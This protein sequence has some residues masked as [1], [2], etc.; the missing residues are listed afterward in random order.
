MLTKCPIPPTGPVRI[1]NKA[2][3][4][5]SQ[6]TLFLREIASKHEINIV[7][8]QKLLFGLPQPLFD[9][10]VG[11]FC[12]AADRVLDRQEATYAT[13]YSLFVQ[14]VS[15]IRERIDR[16]FQTDLSVVSKFTLDDMVVEL[17]T[18]LQESFAH[19]S[20]QAWEHSTPVLNQVETSIPRRVAIYEETQ[21]SVIG[22][23]NE[24]AF[25]GAR[26]L[27][28]FAARF[29]CSTQS[30]LRPKH[31]ERL[32]QALP[33]L[34]YLVHTW[35]GVQHTIDKVSYGEWRVVSVDSQ[36]CKFGI[37]DSRLEISRV[38]ALRRE[39]IQRMKRLREADCDSTFIGKQLGALLPP[40]LDALLNDYP[41]HMI[42]N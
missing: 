1:E 23:T 40:F 20:S 25:A 41:P 24:I 10:C 4:D 13:N 16:Q 6:L 14:Q 8:E 2:K 29:G 21:Q 18:W 17:N 28:E 31:R 9:E 38:L 7:R 37:I 39:A 22:N 32:K 3:G 35:N 11:L 36:D 33:G 5:Y 34:I 19:I 26:L 15:G 30:S 27:N 12:C 42:S